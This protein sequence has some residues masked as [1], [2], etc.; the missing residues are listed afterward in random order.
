MEV[1][2]KFEISWSE[3]NAAGDAGQA[4]WGRLAVKVGE[5]LLWGTVHEGNQ[6]GFEWSWIE[7]LEGL[8]QNWPWLEWEQGWPPG[9]NPGDPGSYGEEARS[10]LSRCPE[11]LRL[12][13]ENA[14]FE[15]QE[16]HDLS[17]FL[18]G[19][20]LPRL[21]VVRE[22]RS[23]WFGTEQYFVRI[24]ADALFERLQEVGDLIAHRIVNLED[25]RAQEALRDWT[26]RKMIHPQEF[27]GIATRLKDEELERLSL[28]D[29]F[30]A[31][32]FVKDTFEVNELMAV[33]RMGS[34]MVP[35]DVLEHILQEV[36]AFDVVSTPVLDAL[37]T[38]AQHAYNVWRADRP[39]TEGYRL[40]RWLRSRLG[41]TNEKK[42]DPATI[43]DTWGVIVRDID[44]DD[45]VI[46]AVACWGPSHGPAILVNRSGKHSR[47]NR[48]RRATLAH[49]ICHLLVDRQDAL[50]VSEVMGGLAPRHAERRANAFQAEFLVPQEVVGLAFSQTDNPVRVLGRLANRY[51]A[52][53]EI[54]AWQAHHSG[55]PLSPDAAKLLKTKVSHPWDWH[56]MIVR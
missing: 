46:E 38:E 20:G 27:L 56:P 2:P 41:L 17:R 10:T 47:S 35:L 50:P 7:L 23:C 39:Y 54:I 19:V 26:E 48:G 11:R 43:L 4:T 9:I 8:A 6:L 3:Q 1:F 40:G 22:G 34:P 45:P 49:E 31:F 13:M 21:W 28:E 25:D 24:P 42:T 37:T 44:L 52:S 12:D 14:F 5:H 32:E 36:R 33:A 16:S 15:F 51:Q 30:S 53:H 55:V 18:D 29:A